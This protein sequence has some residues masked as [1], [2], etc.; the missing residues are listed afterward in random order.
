MTE[1]RENLNAIV[2]ATSQISELVAGIT[3]ATQQQTQQCQSVTQTMTEV[4]A[5]ANKTSVDSIEISTSFRQLLAM[6]QNLRSK[7][8]QFK[9]D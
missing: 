7:S 9:V 1:A 6:A 4:A 3:Q 5:S 2:D 8:E